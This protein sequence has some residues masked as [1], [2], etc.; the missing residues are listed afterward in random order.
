MTR[1]RIEAG[2]V[3]LSEDMRSELFMPFGETSLPKDPEA[4]SENHPLDYLE[5]FTAKA[6]LESR[7]HGVLLDRTDQ[8]AGS[9][10]HRFDIVFP[11][12][13]SMAN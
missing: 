5:L 13:T 8:I 1:V 9:E 6:V 11:R 10:G 4:W 7:A 12:P 2:G 3:R